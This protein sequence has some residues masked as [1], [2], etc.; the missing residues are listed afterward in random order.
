DEALDAEAL[1]LHA[2]LQRAEV[3]ADVQGAGRSVAGQDAVLLR[4]HGEVAPDRLRPAHGLLERSNRVFHGLPRGRTA[5]AAQASTRGTTRADPA[6]GRSRRGTRR[7]RGTGCCIARS[8]R[9][10]GTSRRT[11]SRRAI[12][13]V[14]TRSRTSRSC[15][16]PCR[17]ATSTR[18]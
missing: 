15:T 13:P 18:A 1:E 12:A 10:R 17:C 14:R 6:T 2:I 3:V 8:A 9:G 7:C 4:V 11:R 16:A 5:A